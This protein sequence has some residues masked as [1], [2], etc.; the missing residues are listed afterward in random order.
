MAPL[1]RLHNW[2]VHGADTID[3]A[4]HR[5]AWTLLQQIHLPEEADLD[6]IAPMD[7]ERCKLTF[8]DAVLVVSETKKPKKSLKPVVG[9]DEGTP[10]LGLR[11]PACPRES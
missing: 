8:P 2:I 4:D 11:A 10:L 9:I 6:D 1:Q 7:W 3:R 5:K